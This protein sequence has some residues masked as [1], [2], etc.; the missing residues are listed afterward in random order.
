M[1]YF[2]IKYVVSQ[3]AV[4]SLQGLATAAAFKSGGIR[5][6]VGQR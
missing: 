5:A 4:I 3:N 2:C 6:E 1:Y